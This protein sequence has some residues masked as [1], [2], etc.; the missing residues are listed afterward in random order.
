MNNGLKCTDAVV[1]LSNVAFHSAGADALPWIEGENCTATI[2][3]S[4]LSDAPVAAIRVVGGNLNVA[5]TRIERSTGHGIEAAGAAQVT[6]RTTSIT[7]GRQLGISAD[8]ATVTV[9]RSLVRENRMGG[10]RSTNGVFDIV[11]NFVVRNGNAAN[12]SF[13][14]MHLDS[15]VSTSRVQHNTVV[16]N[17]SDVF[18][19]SNLAGGIYCRISNSFSPTQAAGNIIANNYRGNTEHQNAQI[20]GACNFSGSLV[21][22]TTLPVGCKTTQPEECRLTGDG[23]APN[24]APITGVMEDYDGQP[25]TDGTPDM[26]ADEYHP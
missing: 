17:D 16:L 21:E 4:V 15:N 26:G 14:G 12:A 23:L 5:S 18:S 2:D 8:G 25:R 9:R 19:G 20:A 3:D 22:Q 10:I 1:E 6:V 24:T 7:Q 11:N 13:G